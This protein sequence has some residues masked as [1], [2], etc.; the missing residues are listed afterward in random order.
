MYTL[1]S[2]Y[3]SVAANHKA[4]SS[5]PRIKK[6]KTVNVLLKPR[7]FATACSLKTEGLRL[8]GGVGLEK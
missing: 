4:L 2:K 1:A 8:G 3:S 6:I 7:G 5:K